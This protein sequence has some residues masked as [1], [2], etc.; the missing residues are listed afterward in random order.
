MQKLCTGL[1]TLAVLLVGHFFTLSRRFRNLVLLLPVLVGNMEELW[2][3]EWVGIGWRTG[4]G[5]S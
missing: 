5:K 1:L 4:A 2:Q 3:T